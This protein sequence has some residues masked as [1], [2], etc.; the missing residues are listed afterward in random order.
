MSIANLGELYNRQL[1][2]N[3]IRFVTNEKNILAFAKLK[4]G[5]NPSS[6][7]IQKARIE[8]GQTAV[9]L[10][11]S[12]WEKM[13]GNKAIDKTAKEFLEANLY[14][15]KTITKQN[16]SNFAENSSVALK[17]IDF[18]KNIIHPGIKTD[19]LS[20]LK[21]DIKKGVADFK[22]T[23]DKLRKQDISKTI[24]IASS[25]LIN[26]TKDTSTIEKLT[27]IKDIAGKILA[28]SIISVIKL[29]YNLTTSPQDLAKIYNI[30]VEDA[31]SVQAILLLAS[32]S[33][34]GGNKKDIA[35]NSLNLGIDKK[36]SIVKNNTKQTINSLENIGLKYNIPVTPII[37]AKQ[38]QIAKNYELAKSNNWIN[39][40]T[41]KPYHPN[42]TNNF[43]AVPGSIKQTSL[44]K[45]DVIVRYV[46]IDDLKK[47]HFDEDLG[48]KYNPSKDGGSYSTIKGQSW[49]S[50]SLNGKRSDYKKFEL[51][52]LED[53]PVEKSITTPWYKNGTGGGIQM[54]F[55]QKLTELAKKTANQKPS[56]KLIG[57]IK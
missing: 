52:I 57:E 23:I 31:V 27:H 18:Y 5:E 35:K 29:G 16:K 53:I 37:K 34:F 25:K 38:V 26:Y 2:Q 11:D 14:S 4:Y 54:Q 33:E 9:A 6:N 45:G 10:V 32:A 48:I 40:K 12:A 55:K 51:E 39:P 46:R 22:K 30:S 19:I 56:L 8:L 13:L 20:I 50:L 1:H 7:N 44:K 42:N 49:E 21:N 41:N 43:H 3:E 36:V 24:D 15:V 17:H 28:D 47:H